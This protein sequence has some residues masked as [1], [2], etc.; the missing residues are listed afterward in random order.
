MYYG[1]HVLQYNVRLTQNIAQCEINMRDIL[2]EADSILSV[3]SDI[4][5]HPYKLLPKC[6]LNKFD[7][8][9][10]W[11]LDFISGS[12]A[13]FDFLDTDYKPFSHCF[14][15][16]NLADWL[17]PSSTSNSKLSFQSLLH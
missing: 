17:I 3:P 15:G 2:V 13:P 6:K 1:Y 4:I 7:G 16:I 9:V 8:A 14:G 10:V 12:L 5:S 11:D